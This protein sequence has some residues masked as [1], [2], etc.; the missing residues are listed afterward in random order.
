MKIIICLFSLLLIII[1]F[2][3]YAHA[4]TIN[5]V[6]QASNFGP[7]DPIKID[8]TIDG[9]VGGRV[10]WIAHGPGGATFSGVIDKF[11]E[12]KKT[13]EISRDAFKKYGT[14][15]IDYLY[16]DAKETAL[17]VVDPPGPSDSSN[18]IVVLSKKG[19]E[20]YENGNYTEA[21]AYFDKALEIDPNN[22]AVLNNKGNAIVKQGNPY[23]A[24]SYFNKALKIDPNNPIIRDS[25]LN[26]QVRLPYY[27]VD[28]FV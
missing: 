6:P 10:H 18:D 22:A 9:F 8:L 3:Q 19:I 25:L 23:A 7:N 17:F 5:A 12:N 14:W 2:P 1:F 24:I 11:T 20:S 27:R 16:G 21:I 15:T 4:A 28:G 13:H 26:A